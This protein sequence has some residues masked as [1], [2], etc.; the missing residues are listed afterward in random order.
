MKSTIA[1]IKG[2]SEIQ[3][4]KIVFCWYTICVVLLLITRPKWFS[5]ALDWVVIALEVAAVLAPVFIVV[6]VI[7]NVITKRRTEKYLRDLKKNTPAETVIILGH[8][9][10]TRVKEWLRPNYSMKELKYLVACMRAEKRDFSFYPNASFKE[11]ESLMA[12]KSVN[13]VFFYGHGDT[14]GFS[15]DTGCAVFYCDFNDPKYAK[16]RV[17]Q[18]HCGS[19][20]GGKSLI[21]Y[22]VSD[23]NKGKCFIQKD[24]VYPGQ[25]IKYLKKRIKEAEGNSN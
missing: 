10:W 4:A 24:N 9:K 6:L 3:R 23:A 7:L 17:H 12:G 25:I 1:K 22:V 2:L 14:H 15:L 19:E 21:D 5:A 20:D 11:V 18:T 16:E 13:E 8:S